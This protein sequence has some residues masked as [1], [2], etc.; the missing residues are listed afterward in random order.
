[1]DPGR[2]TIAPTDT[3]APDD[4]LVQRCPI[5]GGGRK[6]SGTANS[7]CGV[8]SRIRPFALL[9]LL[10]L[11]VFVTT[12]SSAVS[13]WDAPI[14]PSTPSPRPNPSPDNPDTPLGQETREVVAAGPESAPFPNCRFGVAAVR[15]PL[16]SYAYSDLNIGWFVNY[17]TDSSCTVPA[18]VEHV[19][20]VRVHQT[21]YGWCRDCYTHPYTYTVTPG[22]DTLAVQAREQPGRTWL[23]GN[24][25]DRRDW[26]GGGQDEMT[27][28]MYARAFHEIA[29]VI[30]SADPG[31]RLALGGVMQATPLRLEY[32][33]LVW[34]AYGERFGRRL[35]DDVDIW[36]VHGFVL[37]EVRD[38][39]GAEIPPGFDDVVG[40]QYDVDDNDSLEHFAEQIRRFRVWMR[41]R[42]ERDKPLY[43]S[44]YGVNMPLEYIPRER[45]QVFLEKT[46]DFM[47]ESVDAEL[48]YP[49]DGNRLVQRFLWYSLDDSADSPGRVDDYGDALFSSVTRE[50]LPYGDTWA[51]YV[52]DPGHPEASN[53]Y[54][55]LGIA[56]TDAPADRVVSPTEPLSVTLQAWIHNSGNTRTASD[57]G[58]EVRFWR[59]RRDEDADLIDIQRLGDL[60]GCGYGIL[61]AQPLTIM[62]SELAELEWYV[63]IEP[64]AGESRLDDNVA[65]GTHVSRGGSAC[66]EPPR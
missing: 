30:R 21:K 40:M 7:T 22:F 34:E 66:I 8:A 11:I 50:R 19:K 62:P 28:A 12:A 35:G 46:F 4:R 36:N 5:A 27:P 64:I 57:G 14:V 53:A 45:V 25:P 1:M 58:I 33:D 20:I 9:A 13:R 41:D 37:P 38:S 54:V 63:E 24:E 23:I 48:G 42:G 17:R 61:V 65:M 6:R 2:C 47:L 10:I 3:D 32:L 60:W 26:D 31:A 52:R 51:Q 44:E 59:G 43:L 56:W 16:C 29:R 18:A 55:N 49:V 39:W 15:N